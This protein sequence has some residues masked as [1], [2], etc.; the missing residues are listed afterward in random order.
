MSI[1]TPLELLQRDNIIKS[2][3][4]FGNY[5]DSDIINNLIHLFNEIPTTDK[6]I[7]TYIKNQRKINKLSS[8]NV[9]VKSEVYG[10]NKK[11]STLF[12]KI[13]KNDIEFIHLT[14]HLVPTTLLPNKSGIIHIFKD[15]YKY[16][17]ST[18]VNNLLYALIS[19]KQPK[20]KPD[21]LEFSIDYG[22]DTP[23]IPT[24]YMYDSEIQ[25]EMDVIISVLNDIFDE[26][27]TSMFIGYKDKNNTN[28]DNIINIHIKT[29]NVL[30]NINRHTKY[31][32]RR[33]K[34]TILGPV[35]GKN[36]LFNINYLSK[37]VKHIN[38]NKNRRTTRKS[39]KYLL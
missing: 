9:E 15:I 39:K 16:Y 26:T 14:I 3:L 35:K 19:V 27:N 10:T 8:S 6:N 32:I 24:A 37:T 13:I 28:K 5:L 25:E 30:N 17:N 7:V 34:G 11:K 36:S 1:Y 31:V 33:N 18:I 23:V 38:K 21:S 29:N 22:Y 4:L 2:Q 12:L 20:G